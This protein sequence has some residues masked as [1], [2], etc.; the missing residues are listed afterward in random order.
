MLGVRES[1]SSHNFRHTSTTLTITSFRMMCH[2]SFSSVRNRVCDYI[3][4]KQFQLLVS[5]PH[6]FYVQQLHM[7]NVSDHYMDKGKVL[8]IQGISQSWSVK[9]SKLIEK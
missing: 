1:D 2:L 3:H 7:Q 5:P 4:L 6:S 9:E 8:S